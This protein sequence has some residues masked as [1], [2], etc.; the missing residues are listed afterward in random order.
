[1]IYNDTISNLFLHIW[2]FNYANKISSVLLKISVSSLI[3]L[4]ITIRNSEKF[5]I[6]FRLRERLCFLK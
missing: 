4:I 1:M 3:E 2:L 6:V 5:A